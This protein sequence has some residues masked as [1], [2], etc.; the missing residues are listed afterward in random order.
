MRRLAASALCLVLLAACETT[1]NVRPPP[2]GVSQQEL[3]P[4]RVRVNYRG[5]SSMSEAEVRDRALLAAAEAALV[6]GFDWFRVVD[7]STD[8]APSTSPRFSFGLG[9]GSYGRRGGFGLGASTSTG[10]GATY[11]SSFEIVGGRGAKPA[12]PDAYDARSVSD[13]LRRQLPIR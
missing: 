13:T 12:D 10:G 7:R 3:E 1:G 4:G 9:T 11:V 5:T 2:V 6:R 8:I